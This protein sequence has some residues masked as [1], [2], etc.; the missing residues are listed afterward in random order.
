MCQELGFSDARTGIQY[1]SYGSGNNSQPVW[2]ENVYCSGD[3]DSLIDCYYYGGWGSR[4]CNHTHDVGVSCLDRKCL[5]GVI[6]IDR[7]PTSS[8][9]HLIDISP[10]IGN[11]TL[12]VY[13]VRLVGQD[14][15]TD[16]KRWSGRVEILYNGTWG[17]ICDDGWGIEDANVVCK[18]LNFTGATSALSELL[19]A[20]LLK[21][22]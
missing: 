14:G 9:S 7:L 19:F 13:P 20:D 18:Q 21:L 5:L 15:S 3:E 17:T 2:L 11:E 8:N 16:P 12:P 22:V 4:Y 10:H 1:F 6:C